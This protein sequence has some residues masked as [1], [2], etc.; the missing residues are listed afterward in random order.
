MK[1]GEKV[2][3][4]RKSH[5]SEELELL[6]SIRFLL[7]VEQRLGNPYEEQKQVSRATLQSQVVERSYPFTRFWRILEFIK[8]F[9]EKKP[10][11]NIFFKS[12]KR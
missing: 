8:S 1:L 5:D 6:S 2:R 10:L 7:L 9:L 12:K 11:F 4:I 3:T